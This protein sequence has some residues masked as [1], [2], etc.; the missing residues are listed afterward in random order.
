VSEGSALAR[1]PDRPLPLSRHYLDHASTT[2][3][4]NGAR[5]AMA[6]FAAEGLVGDPSRVGTEARLL[7]GLLEQARAE[8]AD[9]LGASPRE[10]IF[11]SGASESIAAAHFGAWRAAPSRAVIAAAVEHSSVRGSAALFRET[12]S[13]EVDR[14]GRIDLDH[15]ARL[16]SGAG[17][18]GPCLVN[19]QWANHEVGTVQPVAEAAALCAGHDVLLHVDAAQAVGHIPVDFDSSGIDL[20]SLSAHK[21]GGPVGIGALV[22]RRGVR[23]EPL[24]PGASQERGRR[25]GLE[26]ICAAVGFAGACRELSTGE[27]FCHEQE[28]A[29]HQT[30]EVVR[31]A[32]SLEGVTI[33]GD[34][35]DR[36]PHLVCMAIDGVEPEAV[37]LELD[38]QGIT[39]HSGSACSSEILEPSPVLLAMGVGADRSLRVSVG[40]TTTSADIEAFGAALFRAISELRSLG[41][42]R[43]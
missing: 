18:H 1:E 19:C 26:N 12:L 40:W 11:T 39:V 6:D 10:V 7:R 37:L 5:T 38:R 23:L 21:F 30:E 29:R 20:L 9:F 13:L 2:P 16:L 17:T 36:V 42:L 34:R 32:Q 35:R 43:G 25:A 15:L 4:R 31:I 33:L 41:Q 24:H 28:R 3:L 22:V 14:L 27:R 8:V